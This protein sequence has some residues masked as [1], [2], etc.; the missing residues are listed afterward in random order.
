MAKVT[1]KLLEKGKKKN[2]SDERIAQECGLKPQ[3]VQNVAMM[4][5][6]YSKKKGIIMHSC[7][8][9]NRDK[10]QNLIEHCKA[11]GLLAG[12][13]ASYLGLDDELKDHAKRAGTFH[14]IGK[15]VSA[16]QNFIT[17]NSEDDESITKSPFHHEI[18]WAFVAS[19]VTQK[20][21]LN[22]IYWHHGRPLRDNFEYY[23]DRDEILSKISDKDMQKLEQ[24]WSVL[25]QGFN[26]NE[27]EDECGVPNMFVMDGNGRK[28]TNAEYLLVR[29]CVVSADRHISHY[30]GSDLSNMDPQKEID[31]ILSGGVSQSDIE[32][33][34][35]YD[36]ERFNLQKRCIKDIGDSLTTIVRAPAGLGKTLI[37]VLWGLL[38]G[39]RII[40]VCPRNIVAESVY[41]NILKELKKFNLNFS[42]E[43][44]LTGNRIN[45]NIP[46]SEG[47][48][49]EFN[50]DIIVTNIDSILSPMVNNSVGGRLFQVFGSDVILD[51][52]HE[53]ISNAPMFA[54]LITYMRARHRVANSCHTLLLSA[55]PTN[56]HIMW[57]CDEKKTKQLPNYESHYKPVHSIPYE[58][59]ITSSVEQ[60]RGGTLTI[61]NSIKNAQETYE[62]GN[63]DFLLHS[64]YTE[65]DR[66]IN[67]DKFKKLFKEG[68]TGVKENKNV[69]A[70]PVVQAAMDISFLDLM[71][72]ICSPEATLQR[73]GRIN[74]W[75]ENE[76]SKIRLLDLD[77][78]SEKAAIRTVYDSD[79][80]ETWVKHLKESL[81][82]PTI[83]LS[84][85][86]HI[87]NNFYIKYGE[88]VRNFLQE[89][90]KR[91]LKGTTKCPQ[92]GLISYYP[93]RLPEVDPD[94]KVKG[95][96]NLRQ[97]LGSYFF[98]VQK[99]GTSEWVSADEN[100]NPPF[101]EGPEL[102]QKYLKDEVLAAELLSSKMDRC[103]K[104]L[105]KVG[106]DAYKILLKRGYKKSI[107]KWFKRARNP[108]TPLPDI[109][110]EYDSVLGL[111]KRN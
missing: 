38:R 7:M 77:N 32:C 91:G 71:E 70:A 10:K 69:S 41:E 96:R 20:H 104:G 102:Y 9:A 57:D 42:I 27:P 3:N 39:R 67:E 24:I 56:M 60:D 62:N 23:T 64:K 98:T 8:L 79:L 100:G 35:G 55:T 50:A 29:S 45:S 51:E 109:S 108:E 54:A 94:P 18:S 40:W 103:L 5:E 17:S 13:M 72:S 97:P 21:I 80:R 46:F 93:K 76:G 68:G 15:A 99:R 111:I 47:E 90:Y 101:S 59:S 44:Y 52:F 92:L 89:E 49:N 11:V 19:K 1:E 65:K 37:G 4:R 66:K 16:F 81:K 105:V 82:E 30:L 26:G 86:Y 2:W 87:Y 75:G 31:K 36:L 25:S 58:I 78:K 33:P 95:H 73:I 85:L 63:Y 28:L 84:E 6:K 14:D 12:S 83:T 106:Y 61:H 43:L 53:L 74:R 34:Q 110:R 107:D 48:E 88:Q 22:A